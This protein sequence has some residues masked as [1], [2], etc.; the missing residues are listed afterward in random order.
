MR[1]RG[2][3][4][5]I[6]AKPIAV[7]AVLALTAS[8]VT[9]AVGVPSES[10]RDAVWEYS[11]EV[12]YVSGPF[13]GEHWRAR[14]DRSGMVTVEV[15]GGHREFQWFPFQVVQ[16]SGDHLDR[17][18]VAI[19]E[20]DFWQLPERNGAR[21]AVTDLGSFVL[22]V[23]HGDGPHRVS[24]YGAYYG[25][26]EEVDRYLRIRD[27][28]L[29]VIPSPDQRADP[30]A[31]FGKVVQVYDD[32]LTILLSEDSPVLTEPG[33]SFAVYKYG[34]YNGEAV[35][36]GVRDRVLSCRIRLQM[37]KIR[38]GDSVYLR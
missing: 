37:T 1:P 3:K 22:T 32:Q 26:S 11:V 23:G 2:T 5:M 17:I 4:T 10:E 16:L 36:V 31:P 13:S 8:C 34:D 21:F 14:I 15:F 6:S 38:V 27:E 33:P 18:A 35:V 12:Q 9:D 29:R 7:A 20:N 19:E 30:P 24:D 25:F 28:I